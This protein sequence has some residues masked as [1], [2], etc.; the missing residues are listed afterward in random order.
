MFQFLL[1][2]YWYPTETY[3]GISTI[4]L[5]AVSRGLHVATL[6]LLF[7]DAAPQSGITMSFA[8]RNKHVYIC[9]ER[10]GT[11]I[12]LDEIHPQVRI[13]FA[14]QEISA[15]GWQER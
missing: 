8:M 9:T 15:V 11:I 13:S 2:A 1:L 5:F 12:Q 6:Q 7:V 14:V 10:T 4:Y 3:S